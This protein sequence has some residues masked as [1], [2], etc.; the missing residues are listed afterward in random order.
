MRRL[1]SP[2]QQRLLL[3]SDA[4]GRRQLA[5]GA[6]VRRRKLRVLL[7]QLRRQAEGRRDGVFS[8]AKPFQMREKQTSTQQF[9]KNAQP[10]ASCGSRA[11]LT[12]GGRDP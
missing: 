1:G 5:Q 12:K 9:E 10:H 3:L 4:Q 11:V 6:A 2:Q 8:H 7:K